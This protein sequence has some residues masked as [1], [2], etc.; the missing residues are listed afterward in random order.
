MGRKG[1]NC[2]GCE[3][4]IVDLTGEP[5]VDG[6]AANTNVVTGDERSHQR[7][8]DDEPRVW[9]SDSDRMTGEAWDPS[10]EAEWTDLR[11]YHPLPNGVT[12]NA[13]NDFTLTKVPRTVPFA[14]RFVATGPGSYVQGDTHEVE[15]IFVN[16]G[17]TALTFRF[18]VESVGSDHYLKTSVNGVESVIDHVIKEPGIPIVFPRADIDQIDLLV[19]SDEIEVGLHGVAGAFDSIILQRLPTG[20]VLGDFDSIRLTSDGLDL[21]RVEW[22][23]IK[24]GEINADCPDGT[25][26]DVSPHTHIFWDFRGFTY[27][28]SGVFGSVY[29]DADL[30]SRLPLPSDSVRKT[31]SACCTTIENVNVHHLMQ[32]HTGHSFLSGGRGYGARPSSQNIFREAS[33]PTVLDLMGRARPYNT[34]ERWVIPNQSEGLPYRLDVCVESANGYGYGYGGNRKVKVDLELDLF[35]DNDQLAFPDGDAYIHG[36]TPMQWRAGDA[37]DLFANIAGHQPYDRRPASMTESMEAYN[38]WVG[39]LGTPSFVPNHN[40]MTRE[41]LPH[42][43]INTKFDI[44]AIVPGFENTVA[45]YDAHLRPIY[46]ASAIVPIPNGTSS[47]S[48]Q[49]EFAHFVDLFYAAAITRLAGID[50]AT[51]YHWFDD[52]PVTNN[53]TS[54]DSFLV[55]PISRQWLVTPSPPI[56]RLSAHYEKTVAD[57][58]LDS[59]PQIEFS[60]DDCTEWSATFIGGVSGSQSYGVG[61]DYFVEGY[62]VGDELTRQP[63]SQ[64]EVDQILNL[65][66]RSIYNDVHGGSDAFAAT[67]VDASASASTSD[68]EVFTPRYFANNGD[69]EEWSQWDS[70]RQSMRYVHDSSSQT[71]FRFGQRYL[72]FSLAPSATP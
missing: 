48:S 72:K 70:S 71:F 16:N 42:P 5:P 17:A 35:A 50:G 13:T 58:D 44:A 40:F 41:L 11:A 53:Y 34:D 14:I 52:E 63:L 45:W 25:C 27:N 67:M 37:G 51:T 28:F 46:N 4:E 36:I 2:C 59:P 55:R 31:Y 57:W 3:I 38:W 29:E 23:G 66:Q 10:E 6:W 64:A 61:D 49:Y 15:A 30:D 65:T 69:Q 24:E 47:F 39:E 19:R 33:D 26:P 60:Y 56:Y 9:Q 8:S 54:G 22:T 32:Q 20:V 62:P 7:L 12:K 43:W 18:F 1:C 21:N 68:T